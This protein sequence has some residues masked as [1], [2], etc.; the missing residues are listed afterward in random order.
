MG[1]AYFLDLDEFGIFSYKFVIASI[2]A[3]GLKFGLD[4]VFQYFSQRV[5]LR[6]SEI[7]LTLLVLVLA[8]SALICSFIG[9]QEI[10]IYVI[11]ALIYLDEIFYSIKRV[12]GNP[13]EFLMLRNILIVTRIISI[14]FITQIII[15]SYLYIA[16]ALYPL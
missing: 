8:T 5:N 7:I 10:I 15:R 6:L 3:V 16:I 11:A 14:C 13:A 2:F 12:E 4:S 9:Y 1:A